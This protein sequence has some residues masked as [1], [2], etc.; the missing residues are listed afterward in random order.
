MPKLINN[1]LLTEKIKQ[2]FK[3]KTIYPHSNSRINNKQN[4]QKKL[5]KLY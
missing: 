3:L 5:K 2:L 1:C 4:T